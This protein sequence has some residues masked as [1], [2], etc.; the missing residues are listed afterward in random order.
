MK[1][2]T[3]NDL[4]GKLMKNLGLFLIALAMHGLFF[5]P[6]LMAQSGTMYKWVDE[7]GVVHFS[8]KKPP[9]VQAEQEALPT[10]K[11]S[12]S[13]NPYADAEPVAS[14][15]EQTRQQIAQKSS[16]AKARQQAVNAQCSA[17]QAELSRIEPNRRVFYTNEAGETVRMDDVER[18]NR[19][20]QLKQQIE[21][22]CN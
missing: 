19:V 1:A 11:A 8:D 5:S 12:S 10:M 2:R 16:E 22:N 17:W 7:N 14:Q 4:E 15:A 20:A 3:V 9:E 6:G 18:V 21:Q 13:P